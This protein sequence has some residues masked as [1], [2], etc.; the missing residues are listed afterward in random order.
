MDLLASDLRSH[1]LADDIT[2]GETDNEAVL[3][4]IVF[5]LGLGY[6]TLASVVI[7]LALATTLVFGLVA[8][9]SRSAYADG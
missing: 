5:V 2:V 7:G 9:I 4:G 6:E 1:D 3:G 8:A